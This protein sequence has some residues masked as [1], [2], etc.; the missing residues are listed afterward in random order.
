MVRAL[1]VGYNRQFLINQYNIMKIISKCAGNNGYFRTFL[2]CSNRISNI[3]A[4]RINVGGL[5]Q[6]YWEINVV[7]RHVLYIGDRDKVDCDKVDI[8]HQ[9]GVLSQISNINA[10][11]FCFSSKIS[12]LF[13]ICLLSWWEKNIL[14]PPK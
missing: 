6:S 9:I 10:P 7:W 12:H 8:L 13:Y 14:C 11:N 4:I 1:S 3:G 2:N 5:K